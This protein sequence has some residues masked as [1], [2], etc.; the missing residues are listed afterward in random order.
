MKIKARINYS[1]DIIPTI[2]SFVSDVLKDVLD[3]EYMIDC[4]ELNPG[5]D[6]EIFDSEYAEDD[7]D[8]CENLTVF[9]DGELYLDGDCDEGD[10]PYPNG[11]QLNELKFKREL[12][13]AVIGVL[14]SATDE[15]LDSLFTVEYD[16]DDV[17]YTTYEEEDD[18][19]I[20]DA[21]E[22]GYI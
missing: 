5:D 18:R 10:D 11:L 22:I 4:I 15:Q 16:M 2:N 14:Q 6:L 21:M 7:V 9:R 8:D 13:N 1:I 17:E 20:D 19:A 3:D 12:L